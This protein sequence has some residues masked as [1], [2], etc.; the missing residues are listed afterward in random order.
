M[1]DQISGL[2]Y[3]TLRDRSQNLFTLNM[4]ARGIIRRLITNIINTGLDV[5]CIPDEAILGLAEDSLEEWT[6]NIENRFAVWAR[7]KE[8]CDIKGQRTFGEL[9]QQIKLEALVG[10]DCLVIMRQ[11][12]R[13]KLPQLQII[14]G[15]RVRSPMP[16]PST[17]K[18]VDGVEVDKDGKHIAYWIY[19]GT[20][21]I[22][23]NS[24][25]RIEARGSL[26]G[27]LNAWLVYG[28]DKREDGIRG[29]PLLGIAIQPL[30]EIDR[31]RDSAQRKATIN[32]NI[33]GSVERQEQM[34]SLPIQSSAVKKSTITASDADSAKPTVFSEIL[35]GLWLDRLA[36]GEKMSPYAISGSDV[37]FGPFEAAILCG[38]SWALEIPP[39]ILMLSFKSNYSASQASEQEF[40]FFLDKDRAK[41]ASEMLDPVFEDWFL[42]ELL[43]GKIQAP[44]FLEARLD[45]TKYDIVAAWINTD[46]TGAKKPSIDIVKQST[47]YK[48]QTDQ[49]W[50][51][52][53]RAARNINGTKFY[54]N[55]R[56][57][58]KENEMKMAAML[59]ILEANQKYG[60]AQVDQAMTEAMAH[61]R[62]IK[63]DD[64]EMVDATR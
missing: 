34:A 28:A 20:A 62:L 63:D 43:L 32:S 44:G 56:R 30:L 8:I 2:D 24:Y 37:N 48:L 19:N 41:T 53:D 23:N 21:E 36:P 57:L 31:Y 50:S 61:L 3:W 9:Q 1:I 49:G 12:E 13:T 7:S 26:T 54:K 47:G 16:N 40:N 33:V 38:L 5:E 10:G 60:S 29:E 46:W 64:N 11:D 25:T 14:P 58:R 4:Y 55:I 27:R 22:A 6:E 59:P 51:T 42:A 52:N 39:E 18:I 15:E 35:P 45:P 17:V